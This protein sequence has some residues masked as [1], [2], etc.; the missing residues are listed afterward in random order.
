MTA[1][2]R[3]IPL[4]VSLS[5]MLAVAAVGFMGCGGS[6]D[7]SDPAVVVVTNTVVVTTNAAPASANVAGTWNGPRNAINFQLNIAQVVDALTGNFSGANGEAG[8]LSGS[9]T[10]DHVVLTLSYTA[11]ALPGYFET[12][13]GHVNA[14]ITD[15]NGTCT[16]GN[17]GAPSAFALHK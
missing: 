14:G 11:G 2:R 1:R 7:S 17:G 8:G 4:V 6:D 9:V 10:G 5:C 3:S 15:F 13:D 12:W 16:P